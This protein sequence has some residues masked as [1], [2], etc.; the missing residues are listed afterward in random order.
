MPAFLVLHYVLEFAQTRVHWWLMTS[1]HLILC[2]PFLLLPSI[3]PASESFPMS[4]FFSSGD[5]S[6]GAS[7]SASVL[8]MN[9]QGWFPLK[10]LIGSLCCPRD[11][12]ASSPAPLFKGI[13]SLVLFLL[14]GPTLITIHDQWKDHSLDYMDLCQQCLCFSTHCLGLSSFSCQEVIVFWFHGCSHHPQWFWRPGRGNLS[15][16]PT[17][18]FYLPCSNGARC[19][20]LSFFNI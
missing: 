12:Q 11:S 5:Q 9:I 8:P 17:F 10:W 14:Y 15:L 16:L 1:S 19:H 20:D 3:F 4:L 18:P 13:N 6:T 2:H 7:A